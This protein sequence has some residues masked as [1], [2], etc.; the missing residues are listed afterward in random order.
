MKRRLERIEESIGRY[1]AQLETADRRGG[2][3]PEA[4]VAH[5]K[6]KIVK[7]NK[8]IAR[9]GAIKA[10]IM[11]SRD[12]QISLTDPEMIATVTYSAFRI[13]GGLIPELANPDS[14]CRCRVSQTA[15]QIMSQIKD[16]D[17]RDKPGHEPIDGSRPPTI[18]IRCD[19]LTFEMLTGPPTRTDARTPS[20]QRSATCTTTKPRRSRLLRSRH[21]PERRI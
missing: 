19:L 15:S 16:I 20:V 3:V 5:F 6:D 13:S 18:G 21:R 1:I 7:L 2:A 11:K 4:K 10:E 8:E 9:L 14:S 17:G 12:K